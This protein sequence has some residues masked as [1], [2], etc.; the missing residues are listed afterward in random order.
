VKFD[1]NDPYDEIY[2]RPDTHWKVFVSSKMRGGAL[3]AEREA[4][5]DAIEDFALTKPWAWEKSANAGP[6]CSEAE[7][8]GQ[9]RSSDALVL[10]LGEELTDMT[11]KEYEAAYNNAVPVFAMIE[12]GVTRAPD[13]EA[14]IRRLRNRGITSNF[15]N[16]GELASLVINAIRTWAL[17]LGRN[18]QARARAENPP[19]AP[20]PRNMDEVE[21][22][23]GDGKE[24]MKISDLVAKA[25]SQV[26]AGEAQ[27]ALEELWGAIELAREAGLTWLV[28]ELLDVIDTEMPP[29]SVDRQWQG[30]LLNAR[31][32]AFS[33]SERAEEAEAA[34][35]QML[36][37]GRQL[38]DLDLQATAQQNLGVC[39]LAADRHDQARERFA[40]SIEIKRELDDLYGALQ[41][42]TNL[43]NVLVPRGRLDEADALLDD[44]FGLL[45]RHPDP[46]MR[47]TLYGHRGTIA[48]ARGDF[49]TARRNWKLALQAARRANSIPRQITTM[50]NLG[51]NAAERGKPREAARWYAKALE[52]ADT[53]RDLPQRR[54]QRQA[55]AL[56]VMRSGESE[57]AAELFEKSA[58]EADALGDAHSAA[59]ATGDAGACWLQAGDPEKAVVLTEQALRVPGVDDDHWRAGQLRN[60]AAELIRAGRSREA[61][62]SAMQA[63]NLYTD[64][65]DSA[66]ALGQA[67]EIA[68]GDSDLGDEL[69]DALDRDLAL[70]RANESDSAW[71]WRAAE[72][73]AQLRRSH[74]GELALRYFTIALRSYA[75]R[76]DRR[77]AFF[78]R[79]DRSIALGDL[80]RG[81]EA[82]ADLR[83]CLAIAEQLD[84]LV[85]KWQA[86]RN[87]GEIER[88]RGRLEASRGHLDIAVAIGGELDDPNV[89][90]EVEALLGLLDTDAGDLN[91]AKT[92]FAAAMRDAKSARSPQLTA[93]ALKGDAHIAFL[94]GQ[95]RRSAQLYRRAAKVLSDDISPQRV[96]SLSGVIHAEAKLGKLAEEELND[97]DPLSLR[98]NWDRHWVVSLRASWVSLLDA[99]GSFDDGVNLAALTLLISMRATG[100]EDDQDDELG[101]RMREAFVSAAMVRNWIDKADSVRRRAAVIAAGEQIATSGG[102]RIIKTM[103]D[104]FDSIEEA[105]SDRQTP[106]PGP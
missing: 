8:V 65:E 74:H 73:A 31:G 3:K 55:L 9:A 68:M 24:M 99:P 36:Q 97:L 16:P 18:E 6:Y 94:S 95:F 75:S 13:L 72:A 29:E 105:G 101:P 78:I 1:P 88:R 60:L 40:Q 100:G 64:W 77:Q 37:I 93:S 34:F 45:G 103:L 17:R 41:V 10:I 48:T 80:G 96:E 56:A 5:T 42:L 71:A 30:W 52:L 21:I 92:H 32:L 62:S 33:N 35:T 23:E 106:A 14:F 102:A 46:E 19:A 12:A 15:S 44:V 86:H 28:S 76:G 82:A 83:A 54:R 58:E 25:R 11:L 87:L 49:D 84:D 51:S 59:V 4:T 98:L 7:C 50:Q 70:R 43:V 79:N 90:G 63:A 53:L 39:D 89:R 61:F 66:S 57:R 20:G 85:L 27:A 38:E 22:G 69:V 67:A 2:A 81:S 91:A 104:A 47:N 26:T